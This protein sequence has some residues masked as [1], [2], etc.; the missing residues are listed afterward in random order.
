[1]LALL[2]CA[3]QQ[4]SRPVQRHQ[5]TAE[6]LAALEQERLRQK[7][8]RAKQR[9]ELERKKE[10][11]S[12]AYWKYVS[13]GRLVF[14]RLVVPSGDS[15]AP[16]KLAQLYLGRI[17]VRLLLGVRAFVSRMCVCVWC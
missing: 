10:I 7:E 6:E 2:T 9:A 1:M 15:T 16:P 13:T 4:P 12:A 8:I 11:D 5:P 14:E 3:F 17:E